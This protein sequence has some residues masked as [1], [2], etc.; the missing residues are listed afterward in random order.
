MRL[1]TVARP[2]RRIRATFVGG[3]VAIAAI[4]IPAHAA[5]NPPPQLI[6]TS[7]DSGWSNS[8]TLIAA[9]YDEALKRAVGNTAVSYVTVVDV[10][11]ADVGGVSSLDKSGKTLIFTA[12]DPLVPGDGPFTATFVARAVG[13]VAGADDTITPRTFEVD[14]SIPA[15]PKFTANPSGIVGPSDEVKFEGTGADRGSGIRV[16]ELHFYNPIATAPRVDQAFSVKQSFSCPADL[17]PSPVNFSISRNDLPAG[18]WNVK[19]SATD[20]A[21]NRSAESAPIA[22]L[23]IAAPAA[24]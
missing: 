3:L 16:V 7:V 20:L 5:T 14:I 22:F 18:Y 19:V 8:A 6:G 4:A 21:G 24:P 10:N 9:T 2:H 12:D 17:C 1:S 13:Q 11:R 15:A 23:R